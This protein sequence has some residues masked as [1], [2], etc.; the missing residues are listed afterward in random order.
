MINISQ[1]LEKFKKF[2]NDKTLQKEKILETIEKNVG[3]KIAK[4]NFDLKMG[5]LYIKGSPIM[6]QEV[7]FKKQNLLEQLSSIGI[8]DI[9]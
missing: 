1:F 3:I 8:Y 9:R 4:E 5:I 6:R 7:F 2:D